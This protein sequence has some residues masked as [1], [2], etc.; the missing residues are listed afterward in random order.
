MAIDITEFANVS[1]SVAATGVQGGNFGILGFLASDADAANMGKD[2]LPAERYRSYTDLTGVA[3]DWSASS[4]VYKAAA[5][6]YGQ[7][8][9]PTDFVVQMCY[10]TAQAATLTGG[11]TGTADE[12]KA[13]ILGTGDSAAFSIEMDALGVISVTDL[14]LTSVAAPATYDA[15]AAEVEDQL[16]ASGLTGISVTHNGYQFVIEG[17]ATGAGTGVLGYA[18]GAAAELLGL[19]VHQSQL[20]LGIDAESP[21]AALLVADDKGIEAVGLVTDKKWRDVFPIGVDGNT[22][23]EIAIY[24]EAAKRIFCNTS[25]DL[26]CI[27]SYVDASPTDIIHLLKT[28]TLR[29]S[30]STFSKDVNA[31]PSASVFGRA[32]SVNFSA[33]DSTITLNL[34]QMP[35]I[36]A[37]NLTPNELANLR[38]RFGSAIVQIG[39]GINARNGFVDSRMA[40]GSWLDATHG[41]LWLENRCEVDIFNLLYQSTTKVPYTQEG[42]NTVVGVLDRSLQ[43]AV[44]NGL[45]APGYLPNGDFLAKGY[46]INA[47]SLEDTPSSDKANRVYMGISFDMVGAGA[48][49]AVEISGNFAE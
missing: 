33:V 41:L 47:V 36:A 18:T 12:L 3:A 44:R 37:E 27:S 40:S 31:Y 43:A 9:T 15:I 42:I 35:G 32:A 4:E 49:H 39:T 14:D 16:I 13:A 48:L 10:E 38:A 45:S 29:F 6:F 46:R 7:T 30:L 34:K 19:Q 21:V 24:A 8:P 5:A 26:S 17:V 23:E 25:N 20:S 1:I 28:R 2:I 22:T 11:G